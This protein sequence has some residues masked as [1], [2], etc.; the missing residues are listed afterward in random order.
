MKIK[1]A[2]IALAII[3]CAATSKIRAQVIKQYPAFTS[4]YV[5]PRN[6]E[7][8]L[9]PGYDSSKKYDV[10]YM[11]DGQNVFNANTSFGGV[12]WEMDKTVSRL[13]KQNKIHPVIIVASW[14][15]DK[16]FEEYMPGKPDAAV[17]K[18]LS[19]KGNK[20]KILSGEYLKFLVYELKPFIDK[21]YNTNAGPEHTMLMGSSMGGLIS[22]YAVCEYPDVFGGA[23]CLST[24]WPALAGTFLKYLETNLP[25][26]AR[27]KF[28]F[29]H[30]TVTLDSLYQPYQ[31]VADSLMQVRGYK[32]GKNWETKIFEGAA[33]NE[34]SWQQRVYIPLEFLFKK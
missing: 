19:V 22:C 15:T 23:A 32:K 25:D 13:V 16:R 6:V 24:H 33:H 18:A 7:V 11:Q 21:T 31:E 28:Y 8:M 9:P 4:A 1:N 3:S 14:C 26:P 29:D 10:L 30:G 12:S 20:N 27:H 34:K 5:V 2:F 17:R